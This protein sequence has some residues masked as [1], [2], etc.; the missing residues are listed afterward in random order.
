MK[1]LI[2][3]DSFKESLSA[4]QV[5]KAIEQGFRQHF[6]E[7]DYHHVPIADGGEGTLA[8]LVSSNQGEIKTS[9]VEGPLG[10]LTKAKWGLINQGD[11]AV[12]ELAEA[13]GLALVAPE[14]RQVLAASSYGTGQIIKQALDLGVTQIILCLGGSAT[15]DA[16][17]GIAQALGIQLLDKAGNEIEKGG[18]A[19]SQLDKI[20]IDNL[21]PRASQIEWLLACDVDNPLCGPKGASAV[22]GP[23]K[24]ATQAEVKT[25]DAALAHFAKQ[26]ADL[27]K[28]DHATTSGYG[29]AGGTALG[30][31]LFARPKLEAGIDIV[32]RTANFEQHLE[33]ADLVI[34][35]EGQMDYQTLHGKAPFGVAKA[36]KE[37]GI[38]VIG[39]S[40]SL[41]A[42]TS[43]LE[44]YF[45]AIFD[46]TRAS[47]PLEQALVE[48][49]KNLVHLASNIAATLKLSLG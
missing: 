19:L 21:H 48:A 25:L 20:N 45:D 16:G 9:L 8:A 2:A 39:I 7:A 24:G 36:A 13:S 34:T 31:S 35:G 11:V 44:D 4:E 42:D 47:M 1:I 30:I 26:I 43:G 49:E 6:A 32:L 33:G 10:D 27:T 18:A 12:I 29:A 23:Q 14:K 28:E 37:K 15:N 3:P 46:S 41:G 22:F 17:A 5:A 38:K 40:G